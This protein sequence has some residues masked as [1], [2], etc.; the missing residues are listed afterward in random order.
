MVDNLE[1]SRVV[2]ELIGR[3]EKPN[4][5]NLKPNYR[6]L[7][8]AVAVSPMT[9]LLEQIIQMTQRTIKASA[10]SILLFR[11]NDYE[12]FFEAVCHTSTSFQ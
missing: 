7:R 9:Q 4:M 10:A 1:N 2:A 6:A 12:L 3:L 8:R 11:D 5:D